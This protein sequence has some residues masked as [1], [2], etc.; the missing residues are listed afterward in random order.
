MFASCAAKAA[1]KMNLCLIVGTDPV[2]SRYFEAGGSWRLTWM[3]V[4]Q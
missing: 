3:Q 4:V 1:L 2:V